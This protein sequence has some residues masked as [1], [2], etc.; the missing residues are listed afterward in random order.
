MNIFTRPAPTIG[1]ITATDTLALPAGYD[2]AESPRYIAP[3]LRDAYARAPLPDAPTLYD[4]ARALASE[5]ARAALYE[6]NTRS[7]QNSEPIIDLPRG[8]E[9]L[10]LLERR[11]SEIVRADFDA[12][13]EEAG[14]AHRLEV[15]GEQVARATKQNAQRTAYEAMNTCQWCGELDPLKNGHVDLRDLAGE[16]SS[17]KAVNRI[18]S[19]WSCFDV[20]RATLRHI[21]ESEIVRDGVSRRDLVASILATGAPTVYPGLYVHPTSDGRD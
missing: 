21:R 10:E 11:T 5:K 3:E 20:A 6:E 4:R 16:R 14:H 15:V 1:G 12:L 9:F 19:C 18:R 17:A 2:D 8:A 13:L 7:G